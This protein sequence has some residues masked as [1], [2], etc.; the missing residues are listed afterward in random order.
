MALV[1]CLKRKWEAGS[2]GQVRQVPLNP[3]RESRREHSHCKTQEVLSPVSPSGSGIDCWLLF[4]I[5]RSAMLSRLRF[6]A[7]ETIGDAGK[8]GLRVE[9]IYKSE[10]SGL[11]P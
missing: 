3:C 9:I 1:A 6:F 4:E 8:D 2:L 5:L 11:R 7:V 10:S